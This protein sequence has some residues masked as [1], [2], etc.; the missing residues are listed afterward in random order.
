LEQQVL[1]WLQQG[2]PLAAQQDKG[3][4]KKAL[5]SRVSMKLQ[6]GNKA[7]HGGLHVHFSELQH[8]P[9]KLQFLSR[10][11]LFQKALQLW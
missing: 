10:E 3:G 8:G 2:F 1:C 5:S 6:V 4:K 9:Q 7:H 11:A